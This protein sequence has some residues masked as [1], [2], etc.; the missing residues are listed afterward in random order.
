MLDDRER[1]VDRH[2]GRDAAVLAEG[3]QLRLGVEQTAEARR[4]GDAD[5]AGAI[6]ERAQ[7]VE[8]VVE[9]MGGKSGRWIANNAQ[10]TPAR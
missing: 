2:G 3:S 1:L 5:D 7:V 10:E 6:A 4:L 9:K 8:A